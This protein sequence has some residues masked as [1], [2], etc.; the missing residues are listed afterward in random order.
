MSNRL[1]KMR[2]QYISLIRRQMQLFVG[3][4]EAGGTSR[5][6]AAIHRVSQ[7]IRQGKDARYRETDTPPLWAFVRLAFGDVADNLLDGVSAVDRRN[8]KL[9][10]SS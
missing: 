8:I 2:R 1:L 5:Q 6:L 9:V 4:S 7:R 10:I 3:T